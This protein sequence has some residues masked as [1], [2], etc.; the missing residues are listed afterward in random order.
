MANISQNV[1]VNDNGIVYD[2]YT[3]LTYSLNPTGIFIL[4]QLLEATPVA[5]IPHALEN[6]F[7]ISRKTASSDLDDF[8]QQ[9]SSLNLFRPSEA[10]P[11]DSM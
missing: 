5:E 6:K 1:Y 9:L 7:G 3:G 2:Y 11:D 10:L 8:L 4:R